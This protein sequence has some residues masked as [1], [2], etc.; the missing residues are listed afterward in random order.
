VRQTLVDLVCEA[1][2]ERDLVLIDPHLEAGADECLGKWLRAG[3]LI[4][5]RVA[6]E[7]VP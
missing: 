7:D 2:A 6:D 1:I 4:L 3:G 5:A